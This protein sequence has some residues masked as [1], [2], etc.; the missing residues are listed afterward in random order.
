MIK[1]VIHAKR[2]PVSQAVTYHPAVA[3]VSPIDLETVSQAISGKCTVTRSDVTA[4]LVALEE[5]IV[6]QAK[7]GN[8]VRLGTLGSFRPTFSTK[9]E[10][11]KTQ[12]STANILRV[13]LRF[14]P[15]SWLTRNLDKRTCTFTQTKLV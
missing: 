9:G 7:S 15:S 13:R 4:V 11:D 5:Y 2:N 14:V 8:S 12:V 3:P 10:N 1:Y 6:E